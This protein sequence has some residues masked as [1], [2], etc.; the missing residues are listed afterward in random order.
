MRPPP[1]WVVTSIFA[2]LAVGLALL[3][4]FTIITDAVSGMLP[5]VDTLL[6]AGVIS[7]GLVLLGHLLTSGT[8]RREF[9]S[10]AQYFADLLEAE[11]AQESES[12]EPSDAA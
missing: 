9:D 6:T 4:L 10:A 2:T 8:L 5:S 3:T 11:K 1:R 12:L 7:A